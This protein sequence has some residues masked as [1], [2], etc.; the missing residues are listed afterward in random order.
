MR[1]IIQYIKGE[2]KLLPAI[3]LLFIVFYVTVNMIYGKSLTPQRIYNNIN[4]A[5]TVGDINSSYA[6]VNGNY[7]TYNSQ[8]SAANDTIGTGTLK[9]T[10]KTLIPAINEIKNYFSA[11]GG[12]LPITRGGTGATGSSN[13]VA[14]ANART[15]LS[16]PSTSDLPSV[17]TNVSTI[18]GLTFRVTKWGNVV[19]VNYY[20]NLTSALSTSTALTTLDSQY[21]PPAVVVFPAFSNQNASV[22]YSFVYMYIKANGEVRTHYALD[23]GKSLF[24]T[25]AYIV[26]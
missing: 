22:A 16:V 25:I 2:M 20:G 13:S 24:G 9:T 7:L 12:A 11:T 23:S 15:N 6:C 17:T 14:A 5:F 8:L 21:R 26:S 10:N 19:V 1:K 18:K 4:D 3:I